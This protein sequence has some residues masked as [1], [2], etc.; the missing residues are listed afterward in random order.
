MWFA[1]TNPALTVRQLA[2][3]FAETN[4]APAPKLTS[5]PYPVLWTGGVFSPLIKELRTTRYQFTQPFIIESSATTRELGLQP[6]PLDEALRD[7][8]AR[9]HR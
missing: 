7:T 9:L 1:P 8:A 3:R 4:R 6:I 2:T 5:I